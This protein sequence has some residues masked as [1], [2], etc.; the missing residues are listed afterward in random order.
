[1]VTVSAVLGHLHILCT[2]Y[3]TVSYLPYFSLV[4]S[5][6]GDILTGEGPLYSAYTQG[7]LRP[8][9]ACVAC[10]VVHTLLSTLK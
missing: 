3:L 10:Y 4:I 5:A 7:L 9:Y 6:D 1:M 8:T 2:K